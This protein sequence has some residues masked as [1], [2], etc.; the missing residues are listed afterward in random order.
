MPKRQLEKVLTQELGA[1]WTKH[2]REFELSPIAA[3]SIG[4][5]HRARLLDGTQVLTIQ[6]LVH[7]LKK[8]ETI[9]I[10]LL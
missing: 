10:H 6:I 5:V 3:A 8:I 1:D 2:F 7:I 9:H 4:Q